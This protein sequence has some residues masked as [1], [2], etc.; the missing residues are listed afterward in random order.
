MLS[1]TSRWCG[2]LG[3]QHRSNT[4]YFVVTRK[5]VHQR[6]YCR[7]D[8]LEGRKYGLCKDYHS[9]TWPVP[10]AALAAL[11]GDSSS[12]PAAPESS[13]PPVIAAPLMP[14]QAAKASLDLSA[15]LARRLDVPRRKKRQKRA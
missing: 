11:F 3:R 15:L 2:N 13:P 5:G 4:V 12:A 6:C 14:S 7:C 1:S 8:T 10:A 9:D